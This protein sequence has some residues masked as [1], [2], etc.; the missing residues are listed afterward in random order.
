MKRI[1]AKH[2]LSVVY[3][4]IAIN[5]IGFIFPS[6]ISFLWQTEFSFFYKNLGLSPLFS[7]FFI[8]FWTFI[9][10]GF[11]HNT[12]LHLLFNMILL[13]FV[14]IIFMN[15]FNPKRFLFLYLLGIIFG[16]ILFVL[17]FNIFPVF[18]DRNDILIGASAG[19]MAVLIFL[20]TYTPQYKVF[21]F[22]VFSL[23]LWVF[24]LLMVCIDLA[25]IPISNSG[26]HISHLGGAFFGF[27]YAFSI[28]KGIFQRK[29][30]K[31]K[32]K[33]QDNRLTRLQDKEKE[34]KINTILDKISKSGYESLTHEEKKFLFLASKN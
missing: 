23:P 4:L 14:G 17:S 5:L 26:G 8:K 1:F 13:Y 22:G 27:C 12:F 10:Y 32:K 21:L 18:Y 9:T 30:P 20:A 19:V 24:G 15:L 33:S 7:V 6:L 31:K 34:E 16:G 3:I 2:S 29:S 25:S 11:L 28:K